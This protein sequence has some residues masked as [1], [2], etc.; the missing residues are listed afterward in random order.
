LDGALADH[1]D[2]LLQRDFLVEHEGHLLS[3]VTRPRGILPLSEPGSDCEATENVP[4]C[5]ALDSRQD[6]RIFE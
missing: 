1:A 3:V 5:L 4:F 6:L 2:D